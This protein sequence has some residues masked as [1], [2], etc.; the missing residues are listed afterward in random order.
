MPERNLALAAENGRVESEGWRV[1]KD[2]GRFWAHVIIDRISDADGHLIGFAK[3]TRDLTERRQAEE[4]LRRS[5]EQFRLLVNGVTD[6]A[7]YMLDPAGHVVSWNAGAERIKGYS[8]AEI[9]G[10]HYSRFYG[11]EERE[12]GE[13]QRNLEL[14]RREGRLER[15][16]WRYRKDGSRFWAHVVIDPIMNEA[17]DELVGF[18]KITRDITERKQAQEQ[19]EKAREELFQAQKMEAVG[20]LT[21]GIAH[22]FNNLL[23]A[24]LGSLEMVQKRMPADPRITPFVEGEQA[25]QLLDEHDIAVVVTDQAMPRMTGTQLVAKMRATGN[26]APVLLATGYS[27]VPDVDGEALPVLGKPFNQEALALAIRDLLSRTPAP[28]SA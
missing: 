26:T 23:M 28:Y 19:L 20:Q 4:A 2:G 1:R 9:V 22:D 14:A 15:E 17:G 21:G 16:G 3:I 7:L 18:A 12:R 27:V 25:L 24:I 13:P 8:A 6:Y 11:A 10:Q 5:E